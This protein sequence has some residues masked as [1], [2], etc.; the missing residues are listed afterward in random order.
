M[1]RRFL[2]TIQP[3]SRFAVVVFALLTVLFLILAVTAF[4]SGNP[5][6][7]FAHGQRVFYMIG[8]ALLALDAAMVPDTRNE[9]A[10]VATFLM[11]I[12]WLAAPLLMMIKAVLTGQGPAVLSA[13]G[14]AEFYGTWSSCLVLGMSLVILSKSLSGNPEEQQS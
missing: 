8:L 4:Y 14:S 11:G 3:F 1:A 13:L 9:A 10:A 12:V 5:Q 7:S 2:G 6:G